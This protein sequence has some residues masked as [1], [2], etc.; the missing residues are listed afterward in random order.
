MQAQIVALLADLQAQTGIAILLISHDLALVRQMAGRVAV[1]YA[2][3]KVEEAPV[4]RLFLAP[5]PSLIPPG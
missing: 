3:C 2:G 5:G 1:M 4:E